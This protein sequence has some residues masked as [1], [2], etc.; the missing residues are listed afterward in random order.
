MP[1]RDAI[2]KSKKGG[3]TMSLRAYRAQAA[4]F[5]KQLGYEIIDP[6]I[7]NRI[8]S[9]TTESEVT[10]IMSTARHRMTAEGR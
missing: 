9:A 7:I 5:A 2:N 4:R 6:E 3:I 8:K 1:F 10:R